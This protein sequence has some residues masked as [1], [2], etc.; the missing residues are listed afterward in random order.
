M[1]K[2]KPKKWKQVEPLMDDFRNTGDLRSYL[3]A[4]ILNHSPLDANNLQPWLQPLWDRTRWRRPLLVD[5]PLPAH[6]PGQNDK[7]L[8]VE[9]AKKMIVDIDNSNIPPLAKSVEAVSQKAKGVMSNMAA[10][11]AVLPPNIDKLRGTEPDASA[12]RLARKFQPKRK[13]YVKK[14]EKLL[15]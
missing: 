11:R 5:I 8:L 15:N 9:M 1:T 4:V 2:S 13:H 7:A 6:R 3:A 12:R 10:A 14:A